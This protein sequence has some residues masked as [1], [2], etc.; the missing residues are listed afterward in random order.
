MRLLQHAAFLAFAPMLFAQTPDGAK[1]VDQLRVLADQAKAGGDLQAE[2]S[3][4]CQASALKPDKY[5]KRCELH[6]E[7]LLRILPGQR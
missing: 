6:Q 4:I 5:D 2:A 7:R 1:T 3:Y